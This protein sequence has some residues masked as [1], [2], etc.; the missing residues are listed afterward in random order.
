MPGRTPH[1]ICNLPPAES[2]PHGALEAPR[3]LP[4]GAFIQASISQRT[5]PVARRS[6]VIQ[7]FTYLERHFIRSSYGDFRCV[8]V[9]K[10]GLGASRQRMPTGSFEDNGGL[11]IAPFES[12]L[13]NTLTH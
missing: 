2:P 6:P 13:S 7:A 4:S 9:N 8:K 10:E 5:A 11:N 3:S 12:W 1:R